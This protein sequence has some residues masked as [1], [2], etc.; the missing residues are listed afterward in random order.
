MK[1]R[2]RTIHKLLVETSSTQILY[3][4]TPNE[5]I[6]DIRRPPY[7]VFLTPHL[8]CAQFYAGESGYVYSY[9]LRGA[10]IY[11]LTS[12]AHDEPII[13]SMFDVDYPTLTHYVTEKMQ[14]GYDAMQS[15]TDSEMIVA[16]ATA[17]LVP[18]GITQDPR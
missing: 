3:H 8:S 5:I 18:L 9:E 14:E 15:P 2:Y 1:N 10:R 4:G 13:D 17:H 6:G 12:S 16:F 7:G 11:Q